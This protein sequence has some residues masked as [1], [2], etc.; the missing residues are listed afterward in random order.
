[1]IELSQLVDYDQIRAVL[2]VSPSDLP[3][4]LLQPYQ[5]EDDLGMYLD[6]NLPNW[7]QFDEDPKKL[8]NIKLLAKYYVASLVATT[9]PVFILKKM[10]DG[11]NEGQRSD[12][13]GFLWLAE[14]LRKKADG[15]LEGILA[16]EGKTYDDITY[17]FV[18]RSIP[19][20]DPIT[21]P[22]ED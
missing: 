6:R 7:E 19:S 22:R 2:T 14:S 4:E 11:S 3:D 12:K 8:R 20:R 9:A 15:I 21:E 5:L 17:S 16:D 10:T 18:G 13:D 1:M